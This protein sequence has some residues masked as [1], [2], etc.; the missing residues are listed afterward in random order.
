MLYEVY[1]GNLG[2]VWSGLSRRRAMA[3]FKAYCEWKDE[4]VTLFEDG[5]VIHEREGDVL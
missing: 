5:D 3:E 4:Q 2:L 1:V